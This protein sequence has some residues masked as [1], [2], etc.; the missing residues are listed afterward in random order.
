MGCPFNFEAGTFPP[1]VPPDSLAAAWW[2]TQ[3][4]RHNRL[5]HLSRALRNPLRYFSDLAG[6]GPF[7]PICQGK[8]YLLN[9]PEFIK[10]VLQ[11]NY[12][13][14]AKGPLYKRGLEPLIGNGLPSAEGEFWLR[15]RRMMQ[16]AFLRKHHE[17]FASAIVS[18]TQQ[19]VAAWRK[20]ATDGA[21]VN[22]REDMMKARPRAGEQFQ[23]VR[24]QRPEV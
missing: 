7:V 12:T 6:Q 24:V 17:K 2:A 22:V 11:D 1:G 15:Q 9:E 23:P 8:T 5:W 16:P 10:Q 18:R 3:P 4:A 20:S 19:T 13:N 14:Y 21:P